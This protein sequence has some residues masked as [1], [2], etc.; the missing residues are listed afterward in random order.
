MYRVTRALLSQCCLGCVCMLKYICMNSRTRFRVCWAD[1]AGVYMV[2][3]IPHL[4]EQERTV[5]VIAGD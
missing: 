3:V 2:S 4:S 5:A 1:G